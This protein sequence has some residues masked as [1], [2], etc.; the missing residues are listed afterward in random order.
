MKDVGR[1]NMKIKIFSAILITLPALAFGATPRNSSSINAGSRVGMRMVSP[2]VAP[3]PKTI[4]ITGNT[5]AQSG[6]PVNVNSATNESADMVE[7]I[8]S[9]VL[10]PDECRTEYR[11]CMDE[12][13]L[14]DESEGARC[15][16]SDNIKQSKSLIQEIQTI[17]SEAEKL[18]TEGVEREKLGAKAKF[19]KFG[20]SENAKKSSRASGIDLVAWIN[21]TTN[22]SLEA[23]EDIGDNLYDMASDSCGFVLSKCDTKRAELEEKLYQREIVKDCKAFSAYLSEQKNAAESNKR[24]AQAAVRSATID[25]LSTTNK[26]NRGECLLAYR[27]CISDKGGCGVNFENCLDEK[28]LSR[29]A[30]ACENVLDQ[31]SA[32]KNLVLEDWADESKMI[33]A[34]AAVYSDKN[35]RLTCNAKIRACLEDGC[36]V[37]TD[38]GCLTNVNVAAGICPII[39]ECDAKVPGLKNS[40]NEKLAELRTNFCQSDVDKCLQDK[41]GV[42]YTAPQCVGKGTSEIVA[43]CP[44]DMFASCKN[45]KFYDTIV[46]A[47]LLQMDYQMLQGCINYYN[48]ALGRICGTDMNCL[49]KSSIV[50]GLTTVPSDET[51]LREQVRAESRNAVT[52]MLSKLDTEATIAA[53]RS[54]QQ[55]AGRRNLNDSIFMTTKT[56]AEISAENRYLTD[57][58]SKLIQLKRA[59]AVG[60]S[61]DWCLTTYAVE[62]KPTTDDENKN[63]SYIKS[64][65]FEPS[66]CN[67]HVCRMQRVCTV[68]GESKGATALKTA[69]GGAFG[70]GSIGTMFNVGLGTAIGGAAGAIAGGIG[71]Y[72]TADGLQDSCQEIESCE[73]INV[74]GTDGGCQGEN[75]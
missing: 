37:S 10:G 22:Q 24:T 40:W 69:I 75:L 1:K 73:D 13:C 38:S 55:P 48:D 63:Y 39:N 8:I 42:N 59:K 53:C 65:S 17:Q 49:A 15:S 2:T 21:G 19:V 64:V 61:R 41:C 58:E 4:G 57:L 7:D 51:A 66:L 34:D 26:Y 3:A 23:D 32:V 28:L 52:E 44:Q 47:A 43:L 16:C 54:A 25:M 45:E 31:C 60:S 62:K 18:Y 9:A 27:A 67:C 72:L 29:R 70:G 12:F 46:S 74:S 11:E 35:M 6:T 36:S 68:G 5:T 20:E 14:L 56:I 71:G 50:E 30:N 33:L